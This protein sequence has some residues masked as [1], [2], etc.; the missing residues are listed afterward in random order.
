MALP[1]SGVMKASMIRAELGKTSGSWSINAAE[2]RKLAGKPSG[3]IK[4]SDFYGKDFIITKIRFS[5]FHRYGGYYRE[6]HGTHRVDIYDSSGKMYM[7]LTPWYSSAENTGTQNVVFPTECTD[8][9]VPLKADLTSISK[10]TFYRKIEAKSSLVHGMTCSVYSPTK[11]WIQ[12]L[13]VQNYR[14]Y[15]SNW[16][17]TTYNTTAWSAT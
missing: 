1:S 2:S 5:S 14:T 12:I 3:T 17:T 11:G 10:M 13:D 7:Q 15:N 9:E 4:F 8:F 16:A 6:C